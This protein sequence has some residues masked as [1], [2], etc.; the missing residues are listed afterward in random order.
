MTSQC[1]ETTEVH[2][3]LKKLNMREGIL[4]APSL[5][6]KAAGGIETRKK[7]MYSA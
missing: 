6:E 3:L 4:G 5:Q 2:K 7:K 1:L